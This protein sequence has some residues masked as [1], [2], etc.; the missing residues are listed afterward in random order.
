[1]IPEHSG[2][3][4]LS[5]GRLAE[6]TFY[7]DEETGT[8][9][10]MVE[11]HRATRQAAW[12]ILHTERYLYL[13][14][15]DLYGTELKGLAGGRDSFLFPEVKRRVTEALMVDERVLGTSNFSF[16]RRGVRVEVGFTV[17]TVY[18]DAQLEAVIGGG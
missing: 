13:I 8:V 6:T 7:L 17:H 1:M 15:S 16:S 5:R 4:A 12:L 9:R 3:L 18:G 14:Y 2:G 11:G 10:G